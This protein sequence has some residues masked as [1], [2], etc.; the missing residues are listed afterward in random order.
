[1]LY[2]TWTTIAQEC[3]HTVL[4]RIIGAGGDDKFDDMHYYAQKES[5]KRDASVHIPQPGS[6]MVP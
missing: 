2:E 6:S 1:M 4:Q 5:S 3:I